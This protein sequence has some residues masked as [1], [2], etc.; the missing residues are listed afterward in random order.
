MSYDIFSSSAPT[1]ETAT[2]VVSTNQHAPEGRIIGY[3]TNLDLFV[4]LLSDADGSLS[5]VERRKTTDLVGNRLYLY[6]RPIVDFSGNVGTISVSDGIIDTVFTNPS[7]AYI[8]FTTLPTSD[9]TVS[10]TAVPDCDLSWTVNNLQSSVMELEKVLGPS[11]DST[12]PGIRNLQIAILDNPTGEVANGVLQNGVFLNHLDRDVTIASSADSTLR[13]TRGTAH[14]IQLGRETDNVIIDATG[15]KIQQTDGTKTNTIVL[16][17]KTGDKISWMGS[18]SGE[19]QL[20]L[21]GPLWTSIYSGLVFGTG[22]SEV[23]TGFYG[24]SVLRVHGSASFMGDVRAVGNITIVNTTGTSSTVL[25]DW[26]IRDELFVYG[27]SHLVG[28][29]EANVATIN[30]Q[31]YIEGDIIA[32]N[33]VG[34]GGGGQSLVDGLDCSEVAHSYSYVTKN[35]K[36]YTI[37][38]AKMNTG[39]MVPKNRVYRPWMELGPTNL[40]GDM[41]NITGQLNAAASSSGSHPNILQLLMSVEIVSGTYSSFGTKSGIW[42]PGMMDP[43]SMYV[44]MLNGQSAGFTA[45]VYGYTVETTGTVHTLTR[46]NVFLPEEATITPQTND[47]YML[48]NPLSIEYKALEAEGGPLPTMSVFASASDPLVV[49][50]DDE[51][52]VMTQTQTSIVLYDALEASVDG[53]GGEPVTGVAYIFADATNTDP[54]DPFTIKVR[55]MPMRMP[56]QTPIGE[57]VASLSGGNWTI[58][59]NI[60]YRPNG[61]Y[62]SAWIPVFSDNTVKNTEGRIVPGHSSASTSP[63]KV[64]FNHH[65]GA[66]VDVGKIN[67]DL[68]LASPSS[69][70]NKWNRTHTQMYSFFGQDV[71][72]PHGL[73]GSF[74]HL[75]LTTTRTTSLSTFRDAS[76]FYMDSAIIGIDLSPGI[77][78]AI[79]TGSAGTA[80][81]PTYLRLVVRKDN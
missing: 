12:Y 51:I 40:V 60:T 72:A 20:T 43:G 33:Q 47:K 19:G 22:A 74:M 41:F 37:L 46:L 63:L 45:P 28:P 76:I 42:S 10:Y 21:G 78:A 8:V 13:I 67:A 29:V 75:P 15:F 38:T 71:R 68:Y 6:H 77:M 80:S 44:K 54:E 25:G 73:S 53:L 11:S 66:D 26:T 49:S 5:V 59:E 64:Y 7:T 50:F 48:Y 61:V 52:R 35:H 1:G 27:I 18:A 58:L 17:N 65:L 69:A 2:R 55:A 31:L 34:L 39:H 79:P 32:N 36:P 57:I 70:T 23:T 16:G 62:D 56:N 24:K 9:F 30:E 3:P 14:T 81:A 4:R